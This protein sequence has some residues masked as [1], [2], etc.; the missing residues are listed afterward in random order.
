MTGTVTAERH[1]KIR[2]YTLTQHWFWIKPP[3]LDEP[4]EDDWSAICY[5]CDEWDYGGL[6]PGESR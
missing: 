2:G 1:L 4:S 3:G 6:I 5:L